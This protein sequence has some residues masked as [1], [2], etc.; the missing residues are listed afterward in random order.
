MET[1]KRT[2]EYAPKLYL[3]VK[4]SYQKYD[5]KKQG[6]IYGRN[7]INWKESST[8][9]K[10]HSPVIFERKITLNPHWNVHGKEGP[11]GGTLGP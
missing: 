1:E 6:K 3:Q 4:H 11:L 8:K 5:L 9:K 2:E 7:K 10:F